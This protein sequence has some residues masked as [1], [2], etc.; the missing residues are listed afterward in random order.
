MRPTGTPVPGACLNVPSWLFHRMDGVLK[1]FG[2]EIISEYAAD[3][4]I[5]YLV[6]FVMPTFVTAF[7]LLAFVFNVAYTADL[8]RVVLNINIGVALLLAPLLIVAA[9][10]IQLLMVVLPRVVRAHRL[11]FGDE[12]LLDNWLANIEIWREPTRPFAADQGNCTFVPLR[13]RQLGRVRRGRL[14][15]SE[16]CES[17]VV[18][19]IIGRWLAGERLAEQPAPGRNQW[20]SRLGETLEHFLPEGETMPLARNSIKNL[21]IVNAAL[22]LIVRPLFH[23]AASGVDADVVL[24]WL[25]GLDPDDTVWRYYLTQVWSL[26]PSGMVNGPELRFGPLT[27]MWWH[28]EGW[29]LLFEMWI[30]FA[31]GGGIELPRRG[32]SLLACYL[33]GGY[34]AALV[35]VVTHPLVPLRLPHDGPI[36]GATAASMGVMAACAW[37]SPDRRPVRGVPLGANV[38]APTLAALYAGSMFWVQSGHRLL[39]GAAGVAV[40]TGTLCFGTGETK[41]DRGAGRRR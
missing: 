34:G 16:L 30:L 4:L 11:G 22:F 38:M 14:S 41:P 39:F 24:R 3:R 26:S 6:L 17:P 27:Y 23:T 33:A 15:H 10:S 9:A 5:N 29:R 25:F 12:S 32:G 40:G 1:H 28:D 19:D 2:E 20:R 7:F 37:L 18:A 13:P 21:L 31:F 35:V 8:A 36:A